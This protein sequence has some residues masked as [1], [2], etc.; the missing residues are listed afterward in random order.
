MIATSLIWGAAGWLL[1]ALLV[2][3]SAGIVGLVVQPGAH[4]AR[5]ATRGHRFEDRWH[6]APVALSARTFA[7]QHPGEAGGQSVCRAGR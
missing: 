2:A 5:C 7:Q 4:A 1:P 3:A 6:C